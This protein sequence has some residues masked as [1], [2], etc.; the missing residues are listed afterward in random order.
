MPMPPARK[1]QCNVEAEGAVVRVLPRRK[2]SPHLLPLR[3]KK[4]H[5]LKLSPK[6]YYLGGNLLALHPKSDEEIKEAIRRRIP[7]FADQ[8]RVEGLR[9]KGELPRG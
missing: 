6:P 9:R 5:I 1:P 4:Q 3:P 7:T 8:A 2:T